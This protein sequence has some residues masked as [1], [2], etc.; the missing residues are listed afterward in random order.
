MTSLLEVRGLS[1][2]FDTPRGPAKAVDGVDLRVARGETLALVGESGSGKSVAAAS[3]LR[4]VPPPGRIV[5]GEVL[6]DGVDLLRL[7][8]RELQRVRGGRVGYVFQDLSA[9]N[10]VQTVGAQ[11]AEAVRL[12]HSTLSRRGAWARAVELLAQVGL[13]TPSERAHSPPHRLSGGQR[14]RVLIAMALAGEPE[15]LIADEPTTA[16]DVST[17]AQILALLRQLQ[18]ERGLALLLITHD[19][20]VVRELADRIAVMYA[21]RIVEHGAAGEL[22][23]SPSHPYTSGLLASVDLHRCT[24]GSRLPEIGGA[25]PSLLDLPAGCAFAPR[26][27]QA[28]ARCRTERPALAASGATVSACFVPLQPVQVLAREAA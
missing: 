6:L 23:A 20:A 7:A 14:Q 10:P 9:L 3:V 24:P 28:Q 11:V 27:G 8:P 12:H 1:T 15:L 5:A 22:T 13:P 17:Q 18:R 26:C 16:L 2:W 4:L 25:V 21:G 19:L